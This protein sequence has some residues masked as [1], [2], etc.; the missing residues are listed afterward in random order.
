MR[1]LYVGALGQRDTSTHRRDAIARLGHETIDLDVGPY[2]SRGGPLLSKIRMRTLIGSAVAKLNHD[3][4]ALAER[5]RPQ[6]AWFDKPIYVWPE[7]ARALR[8][9]GAY[10]IHFTIDNPFGPRNDP[11]WRHTLKA[12]PEYDLHLVQRDSNVEEYRAA[13]ARDVRLM[14]TAYEPTLHYPPPEAWSD[15]DRRNDVVFI[16]APY[17][18][19]PQ[20]LTKLWEGHGIAAKIWGSPE[21]EKVLSPPV[22][23]NLWQGGQ[24]WN[25]DY[26]EM[27]WRS[28]ICLA[29]V[30]HSNCD[31]VAHKSFEIAGCG[32]FLLAE[33]TPGHRTHFR[34][35]SEA[36]YFSNVDDCAA[37]I[38][39]YLPDE[40]ARA[41]VSNAGRLR[42]QTSGYGNDARI[43]DVLRYAQIRIS[44]P[45]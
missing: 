31:D 23:E 44:S 27:I 35:G 32:G 2:Y 16:G 4:V 30:T 40:V 38:R 20:F 21:W 9:M 13:G 28:R 18:R 33:D 24:L 11:G 12:L 6:V 17:D 43:E 41:R 39:R 8:T 3:V 26:R 1:V 37:S 29:F 14:R 42:A 7:T 15:A 22:R 5:C 34:E 19:R 25:A 45:S 10:T 36:V